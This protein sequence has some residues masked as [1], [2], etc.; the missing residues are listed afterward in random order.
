MNR[1]LSYFFILF[2][3]LFFVVPGNC[4][5]KEPARIK[6][7]ATTTHIASLVSE[8]GGERVDLVTL[9]PGG[10]CPGHFDIGPVTARKIADADLFISHFWEKRFDGILKG[11]NSNRLIKKYTQTKGNWMVPEVNI[12]AA[13]EV[14]EILCEIDGGN[15]KYYKSNLSRYKRLVEVQSEKVKKD[16]GKYK[17]ISVVCS[18]QQEEF[19]SLAGVEYCRDLRQAG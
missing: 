3:S 6:V 7:V 5:K 11:I 8:I 18:D 1:I 13:G 17:G 2:L 10:A 15:S 9:I 12:A 16:F 4:I 19:L 14:M